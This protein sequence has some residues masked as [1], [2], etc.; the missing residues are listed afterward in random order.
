LNNGTL[1]LLLLNIFKTSF[2]SKRSTGSKGAP[3]NGSNLGM[4]ALD[5]SMQMLPSNIVG[6]PSPSLEMTL[7]K[8]FQ[9]MKKKPISSGPPSRKDWEFL[10]SLV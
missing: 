3:L 10:N 7:G 6:T 4:N 1:E 9:N 8:N 5:S 2:T